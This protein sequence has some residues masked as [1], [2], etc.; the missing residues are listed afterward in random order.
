[1]G[2]DISKSDTSNSVIEKFFHDEELRKLY[3]A[4]RLPPLR[5]L[6]SGA[7]NTAHETNKSL[8]VNFPVHESQNKFSR[9]SGGGNS[10]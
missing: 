6:E 2:F 8:T 10:R 7:K 9:I 3:P 4:I 5:F 1:M